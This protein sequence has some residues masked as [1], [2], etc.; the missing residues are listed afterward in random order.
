MY[1]KKVRLY[2]HG[3][4]KQ[5]N[6]CFGIGHMK[7]DCKDQKVNWKGYA[8]RKTG[9]F[10]DLMFG[11]WLESESGDQAMNQGNTNNP[12]GG[13]GTQGDKGKKIS[14]LRSY[15]SNPE[16]LK[17]ALADD[18]QKRQR[19]RTPHAPSQRRRSHSPERRRS[20]SPR[21][22]PRRNNDNRRGYNGKDKD[23]YNNRRHYSAR[24]RKAN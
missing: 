24:G 13:Q 8:V 10:E 6:N 7:R 20:R 18:L 3:M 9:R 17:E 16:A 1:G 22:S 11:S 12:N 14:D 5:C 23:K 2:H 19:N 15:L 21:R 4:V